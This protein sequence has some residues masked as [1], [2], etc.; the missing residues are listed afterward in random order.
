MERLWLGVYGW[1]AY[2]SWV[3]N[4]ETVIAVRESA[5][6]AL[7]FVAVYRSIMP[8]FEIKMH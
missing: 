6:R 1:L 2:A 4:V 5:L 8:Y 3:C 7:H